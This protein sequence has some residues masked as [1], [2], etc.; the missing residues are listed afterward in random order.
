MKK[1]IWILCLIVSVSSLAYADYFCCGDGKTKEQC[2]AEKD[3]IY[4]PNDNSCRTRCPDVV[5]DKNSSVFCLGGCIN[6]EGV[7]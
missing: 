2:C 4:C 3:K 7:C 1:L 5:M 6:S